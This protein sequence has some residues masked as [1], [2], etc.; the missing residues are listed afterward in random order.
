MTHDTHETDQFVDLFSR[1]DPWAA[2]EDGR[3]QLRAALDACDARAGARMLAIPEFA[4]LG[5]STGTLSTLLLAHAARDR[6]HAAFFASLAIP[7]DVE[8]SPHASEDAPQV[9]LAVWP[10]VRDEVDAARSAMLGA[11]SSLPSERWDEVLRPPWAG[12]GDDSVAGLLVVRAM[13]D[14]ILADAIGALLAQA[15][16]A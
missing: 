13:S 1:F 12:A 9:N 14:G 3:R 8:S 6:E 10:A 11:A 2:L 5:E 16:D 15:P 4:A 7:L